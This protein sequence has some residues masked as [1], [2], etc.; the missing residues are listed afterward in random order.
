M[1]GMNL[2]KAKWRLERA[3]RKIW[4]PVTAFGMLG[5]ATALGASLFGRF[6]PDEIGFRLGAGSVEQILQIIATS[7]LTVTTFSLSIMVTAFGAAQS[8]ATPRAIALLQS[9]PTTQRVL[10]TFIGAFVY[11]LVGIIAIESGLYDDSE[12]LIL[13]AVTIG[14]IALIVAMLLRWIQHLTDF[15][16][17]DDTIGRVERAARDAILDRAARPS[18]GAYSDCTPPEGSWPIA[19][20]RTGHVQ[21]IDMNR[22]QDCAEAEDCRF[23]IFAEPGAFAHPASDLV[24]CDALPTDTEARARITEAV[25][26]AISIDHAR[27]F[28]QDP[29]FGLTTLAEIGQRA[30]SP[31]VNDPGTAIDILGRLVRVLAEWRPQVT[32]PAE[33]PDYDRLHFA[34][35]SGD[36]LVGAGFEGM[37][38]DGAG[39]IEV[40]RR[41]QDALWALAR[42]APEAF[43]ARA[44]E[45]A[46]EAAQMSAEALPLE[47]QRAEIR[48]LAARHSA[49]SPAP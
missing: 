13:F 34:P 29:R 11:A 44:A 20:A 7:M 9:D 33:E 23:W 27:D 17:L 41:L 24:R 12:R 36:A 48:A 28:H 45:L 1:R 43:A 4:V 19:P 6:I 10:A 31:G 42:I 21:H 3:L 2:S 32:V 37:A 30:L 14:V 40:A 18:L 49:G 5:L 39:Q 15:G 26:D 35:L 16:R 22:L 38:R 25:R 47:S 8:G 46:Q